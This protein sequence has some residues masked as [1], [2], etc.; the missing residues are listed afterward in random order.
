MGFG[1]KVIVGVLVGALGTGVAVGTPGGRGVAVA[2]GAVVIPETMAMV[3]YPPREIR[4]FWIKAPLP[5]VVE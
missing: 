5:R 4:L 3:S 1:V 2:P